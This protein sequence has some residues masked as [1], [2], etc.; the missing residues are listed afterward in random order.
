MNWKCTNNTFPGVQHKFWNNLLLAVPATPRSC[1]WQ[2]FNAAQHS[3]TQ[4]WQGTAREEFTIESAEEI[5]VS[6]IIH[7]EAGQGLGLLPEGA[8]GFA[9]PLKRQHLWAARGSRSLLR[10]EQG[11]HILCAPPGREIFLGS[12][13]PVLLLRDPSVV[14]RGWGHWYPAVPLQEGCMAAWAWEVQ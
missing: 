13:G 10:R 2:L 9:R 3:F 1:R 6:W 12:R 5:R 7:L 11:Q 4:R 14:T 8:A